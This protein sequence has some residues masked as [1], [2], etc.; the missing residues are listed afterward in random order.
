MQ[1]DDNK[2]PQKPEQP[3]ESTLKKTEKV[4]KGQRPKKSRNRR[5]GGKG[6]NRPNQKRHR[7][8]SNKPKTPLDTVRESF[9]ACGRCSFFFSGLRALLG[10]DMVT[11][12]AQHVE[13]GWLQTAWSVELRDLVERSYGYEIYSDTLHFAGSCKACG[14]LFVVSADNQSNLAHFDIQAERQ[15][16]HLPKG[17][18]RREVVLPI[19]EEQVNESYEQPIVTAESE[20][21]PPPADELPQTE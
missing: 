9:F 19:K 17:N 10:L 21:T 18:P 16:P 4:L 8:K 20:I 2:Q 14:R 6:Q 7:P 1:Q 3:T 15:A 13:K 11:A 5:R 12:M